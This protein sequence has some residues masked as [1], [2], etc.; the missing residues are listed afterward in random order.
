MEIPNDYIIVD[1][2]TEKDFMNKT[3]CGYLKKDVISTFNKCLLD[4]KI[5]EACN[6][7]IELLCSGHIDKV[8]DKLYT[9]IMKQI[10]INNL[11]LLEIYYSRYIIYTRFKQ[12]ANKF[13]L[14]NYQNIRNH[15]VELC[16]YVCLSMKGKSMGSVKITLEMFN[17]DHIKC[18][19]R[20]DKSNYVDKYYRFGDPNELKMFFNEFIYSLLNKNLEMS[21]Y[22]LFWLTEWE[23]KN[24]KK[25]KLYQ[26]GYRSING[27]DKKY[28]T[29]MVWIIWDILLN[30]NSNDY[31]HTLYNLYRYEYAPSKKQK[32][33]IIIMVAIKIYTDKAVI[34]GINEKYGSIIIQACGNVNNLFIEKKKYEISDKK[35][36]IHASN[37]ETY[38]NSLKSKS[39]K[40][41]NSLVK[42]TNKKMNMISELDSFM[43]TNLYK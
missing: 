28:M 37:L 39:S 23:K 10:N 18:K 30:L 2:R 3:F 12:P 41:T 26:C 15:I 8:Y 29:D 27:I 42:M 22:W 31:L 5:E 38:N 43:L 17:I 6:W 1:V 14:R 13:A 4:G 7:A 21:L 35:N 34:S 36:E 40:K 20:A 32:K 11:E 33:I 25:D 16:A 19:L 9:I 24:I